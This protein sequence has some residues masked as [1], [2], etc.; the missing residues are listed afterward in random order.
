FIAGGSPGPVLVLVVNVVL[1]FIEGNIF[2]PLIIGHHLSMHPI[3]IIV[4][5]LFFGSL[6]GAVG[7][8]FASPIAASIRVV[9]NFIRDRRKENK[10][11]SQVEANAP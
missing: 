5:I 10:K 3:V 6:F 4:S 1:Q 11:N 7:V 9:S 2:Q 8:I